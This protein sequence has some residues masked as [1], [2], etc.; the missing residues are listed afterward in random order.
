MKIITVFDTSI[1]SANLG[2]NIIMRSGENHLKF[3]LDK[4]F[5]MRLTTHLVNF[6]FYQY[7][8]SGTKVDAIGKSIYKFIIGTDL[9][10]NNILKGRG[11]WPI[12]IFSAKVYENVILMGVGRT[13]FTYSQKKIDLYSRHIYEK[14]L[15]KDII[16]STR[17]EETKIFLEKLGFKA[18]NTGCPTLWGLTE[19]HC[20]E[21]KMSKSENVIIS[22]NGATKYRE[23]ISD[24]KFLSIIERNYKQVYLWIQTIHDQDY[25]DKLNKSS[26]KAINIKYIYSLNEFERILKSGDVDYVGMRL[27]GGIFALQNK[28][29]S[30]IIAVDERAKGVKETNNIVCVNR[31][32]TDKIEELINSDFE[33]CIN[34]KTKEIELFLNQF[35]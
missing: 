25:F 21:I 23:H 3:L 14:I 11:Q 35:K 33:T 34:I 13:S 7:L 6:H 5:V 28:V 31:S 20:K 29:R 2:D 15:R 16:H 27:H 30:I 32:D 24:Q 10:N 22:L 26:D 8:K 1:G 18:I 12:D 17:D 19:K 4:Y 9:L